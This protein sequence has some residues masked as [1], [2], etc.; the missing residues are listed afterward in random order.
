MVAGHSGDVEPCTKGGSSVA[1]RLPPPQPAKPVLL[2][3]R[4]QLGAVVTHGEVVRPLG[5]PS[6]ARGGG[7]TALAAHTFSADLHEIIGGCGKGMV[8]ATKWRRKEWGGV[9]S[10]ETYPD[11]FLLGGP[12]GM[13]GTQALGVV[14]VAALVAFQQ[15]AEGGGGGTD[16]DHA[17]RQLRGT[18][19]ARCP[20]PYFGLLVL[21]SARVA[22]AAATAA[23]VLQLLLQGALCLL[24]TEQVEGFTAH[25]TVY[26]LYKGGRGQGSKIQCRPK[27]NQ[28]IADGNKYRKCPGDTQD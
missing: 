17:T 23:P 5:I 18:G 16:I 19:G 1:A 2:T 22:E 13:V 26:K 6:L 11:S 10:W 21:V 25:L 3:F 27:I 9:T 20:A 7:T 8:S 15:L 4:K 24:Q 14:A 28:S 12:G